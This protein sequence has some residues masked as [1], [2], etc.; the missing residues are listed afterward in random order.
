MSVLELMIER[1]P[2]VGE[3]SPSPLFSKRHRPGSLDFVQLSAQSKLRR[4]SLYLTKGLIA[5][6]DLVTLQEESHAEVAAG[7]LLGPFKSEGE[8]SAHLGTHDWS[9]SPR[10]VLRAPLGPSSVWYAAPNTVLNYMPCWRTFQK[11]SR[12]TA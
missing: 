8:V 11:G 10:F 9:L 12:I 2:L 5:K 6:E 3:E 1:V 4:Q 7:Y